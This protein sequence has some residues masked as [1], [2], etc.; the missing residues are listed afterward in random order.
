[1][2]QHAQNAGR[3]TIGHEDYTA[4]GDVRGA[5][6][7][8]LEHTLHQFGA[9]QPQ[10]RTVLKALVTSAGTKQ[11]VFLDELVARVHTLG[12]ALSPETLRQDFLRPLVQARLVRAEEVE[13]H[14]RYELVHEYLVQQIASWI[15]EHERELTKVRE[16]LDRAYEGYRATGLLLEP[17]A[18]AVI[19]PYEAQVVAAEETEKRDFLAQSRQAVRRQRR[20]V[21]LK[22]G[23]LLLVVAVGVGGVFVQR[24]YR[25]HQQLQ[26]A[27]SV[28][29]TMP[30][31]PNIASPS[32]I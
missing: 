3:T 23:V 28:Q 10:A 4:I 7:Q 9:A 29:R 15:A 22:V 13:G 25:S 24:L 5:L 20:G 2:Y 11:A 19:T 31:R 21:L 8:Y 18:L 17:R 14:T 32:S 27:Q 6:G 16:L 12:G 26:K 30:P 1:M